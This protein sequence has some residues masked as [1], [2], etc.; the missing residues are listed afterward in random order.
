MTFEWKA[1]LSALA[2]CAAL[3]APIYAQ[4]P[5]PNCKTETPNTPVV[6]QAPKDPPAVVTDA[7]GKPGPKPM[8]PIILG[9]DDKLAF[10]NAPAGFDVPKSDIAHGKMEPVEYDSSVVGTKRKL[11]VYTPPGYSKKKRYPVLYLLHGIGGDEREWERGG[12]PAAIL[13]NLT[14]ENKIT[15][16][17]VVMPNGR[18]QKNDRAEGNVYAHAPAFETFEF[19]L[20]KCVVPFIEA[21]YSVKTGRENR[22]LAGL[23]MG[24]G[25]ALN[26]GLGN[27]DTFSYI[28]GF[29]SAPNTRPPEK[30]L[31][32]PEKA[33]QMAK[34]VWVSCGDR[35]GLIRISQNVHQYLKANDVPH[36]WHVEPG[37]HDFAVW[38]ND[39]Y[40]FSQQ[41]F[42]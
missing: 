24:G 3:G 41:I 37:G 33:R 14:T 35:D 11:L 19:D 28:G 34:L 15:P 36:I 12:N 9:P 13:D 10:P 7:S 5:M 29:S 23:S 21:N 20:L 39:L 42:K 22:A 38:K 6:A 4:S 16:M 27:L 2:V 30:L 31:P 25:Q 26:F 18:A 8:P 1:T 32:Y 17:V 40:L